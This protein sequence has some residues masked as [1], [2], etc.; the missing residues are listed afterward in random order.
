MSHRG[1]PSPVAK[2]AWER[3][4]ADAERTAE[5]LEEDGWTALSIPTGAVTLELPE[6]GETDRFGFVHTVPGNY[7]SEFTETFSDSEY[8]AYDVFRAEIEREVY[9]VTVLYAPDDRKAVLLAGVYLSHREDALEEIASRED[10]MYTHLQ[11]LDG[12]H[13]LSVKHEQFEKFFQSAEG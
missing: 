10:E 8:T 5:E 2:D 1:A 9:F 4:L 11:R 7:A 12:S 3:T 6:V 13:L